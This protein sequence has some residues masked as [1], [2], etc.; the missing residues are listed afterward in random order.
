MVPS[1]HYRSQTQMMW[2]IRGRIRHRTNGLRRLNTFCKMV[3]ASC[4]LCSWTLTPCTLLSP[5]LPWAADMAIPGM[6]EVCK[7]Q[8]TDRAVSR[9]VAILQLECG[10]QA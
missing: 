9:I 7:Q 4:L 10:A 2:E 8:R 3:D 5:P 1:V 6:A